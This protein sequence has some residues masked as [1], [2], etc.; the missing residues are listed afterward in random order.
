MSIR[1]EPNLRGPGYVLFVNDVATMYG[2]LQDLR[3]RVQRLT[4][5]GWR[6]KM[7]ATAKNT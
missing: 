6:I 7:F 5:A 1:F 4:Q 3:R 2:P